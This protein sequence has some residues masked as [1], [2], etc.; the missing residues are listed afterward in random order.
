M[1]EVCFKIYELD[2]RAQ[3]NE[4]E[5]AKLKNKLNYLDSNQKK[6]SL[7]FNGLKEFDG[8]SLIAIIANIVNNTMKVKCTSQDINDIYRISRANERKPEH[9]T[10]LV[11]FTSYVKENE[12]FRAKSS[13]KN[14]EILINEDLKS[15][16]YKL[17][18]CAKK[19]F[20]SK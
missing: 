18:T 11:E 7:R 14:T 9:R 10:I 2:N 19:Q 13:L 1:D 15:K 17:L 5:I 12:I 16:R 8:E 6:K 20:G 3:A 4:E